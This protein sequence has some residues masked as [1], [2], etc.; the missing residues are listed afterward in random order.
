[1]AVFGDH[2]DPNAQSQRLLLSYGA[3]HRDGRAG[4]GRA[5]AGRGQDLK[6]KA[7][8]L[9]REEGDRICGLHLGDKGLG[10]R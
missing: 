1:M 10:G 5:S 2:I 4:Q 3:D 7:Q 6:E 9:T 8:G